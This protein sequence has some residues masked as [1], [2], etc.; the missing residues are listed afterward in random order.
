MAGRERE[1]S[2]RSENILPDAS[3]WIGGDVTQ[4]QPWMEVGSGGGILI[5]VG[6][7]RWRWCGSK[8]R[9]L[10]S[11]GEA[12][13]AKQLE[14]DGA[15]EAGGIVFHQDGSF[16]LVETHSANAVDIGE[17]RDRAHGVFSRM[18]DVAKLYIH[19][20]GHASIINGRSISG[21]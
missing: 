19:V 18:L 17:I 5:C 11:D 6:R 3:Q 14:D 15:A 7:R 20:R 21:G 4:E 10:F 12:S 9:N 1:A 8:G 2:I 16:C 13:T